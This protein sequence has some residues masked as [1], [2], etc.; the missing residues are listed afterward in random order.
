[1]GTWTL[2]AYY[3]TAEGVDRE[4]MGSHRS[5]RRARWAIERHASEHAE[6]RTH[7]LR[8]PDDLSSS[9]IIRCRSCGAAF[10]ATS[11]V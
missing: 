5:A 4:P 8:D 7:T 6:A 1:M 9:F 3:P 2:T 10:V 11:R